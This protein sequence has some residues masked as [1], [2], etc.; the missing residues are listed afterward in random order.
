MNIQHSLDTHLPVEAND[1]NLHIPTPNNQKKENKPC[2][3]P[4][5]LLAIVT[6]GISEIVLAVQ[7]YR[8]QK[9]LN[10]TPRVKQRQIQQYNK[11]LIK[12]MLNTNKELPFPGAFQNAMQQVEKDLG[13]VCEHMPE[14]FIEKS[15]EELL[16]EVIQLP[17]YLTEATF[18]SLLTKKMKGILLQEALINGIK[19]ECKHRGLKEDISPIYCLVDEQQVNL[20]TSCSSEEE[21]LQ[22]VEVKAKKLTNLMENRHNAN[23]VIEQA[24]SELKDLLIAKASLCELLVPTQHNYKKLE[25]NCKA[26]IEITENNLKEI[27]GEEVPV[28]L[29]QFYQKIVGELLKE[30]I[31]D[32]NQ[33]VDTASQQQA[34]LS[35]QRQRQPQRQTRQERLEIL[36]ESEQHAR[37]RIAAEKAAVYNIQSLSEGTT[38]SIQIKAKKESQDNIT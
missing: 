23:V 5:I 20:L 12:D 7:N 38:N 18:T 37:E 33:W 10:Y 31:E 15:L 35:T 22:Q 9:N 13:P 25:K 26:V 8:T 14:C 3:I 2:G 21:I 1:R 4:R 32:L 19:E 17:I 28:M 30:Q 24:K 27:Y 11:S 29:P 34:K 36:K 16:P 6:L